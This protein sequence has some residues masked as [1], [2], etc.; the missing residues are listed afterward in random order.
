MSNLKAKVSLLV[1][2]LLV[3]GAFSV[4]FADE[5]NYIMNLS[6][7]YDGKVMEASTQA[8]GHTMKSY[9]ELK[10]SDKNRTVTITTDAKYV[11]DSLTI[12]WSRSGGP[13]F[14]VLSTGKKSATFEIPADLTEGNTTQFV[15]EAVSNYAGQ[16]YV[17]NSNAWKLDVTCPKDEE[18]VVTANMEHN[19]VGYA[20]G[21][22]IRA[23]A[24]DTI[25]ITGTSN[26]GVKLVAYK[27]DNGNVIEVNGASTTIA[28][29]ELGQGK[30][31][32]IV[33]QAADG[34]WSNTKTFTF[35]PEAKKDETTIEAYLRVNGV[36]VE[37]GTTVKVNANTKLEVEGVSNKTVKVVS[38]KWANG[39]VIEIS[40]TKAV[41]PMATN[42]Q[43]IKL[44]ITAQAS[45][46]KWANSKTF[47]I[48]MDSSK[49]GPEDDP[50]PVDDDDDELII[51]PWMKENK[52]LNKLAVSLRSEPYDDEEDRANKNIYALGEKVVYYVDYKN[53][54]KNI[55]QPVKLTLN[56]P[57]S[58]TV[59]SSDNGTVDKKAGT[60]TWLFANG[61][62]K[63]Q[64]GTKTVVVKFTSL[65][66]SKS[67]TYKRI[68]P[69]AVIYQDGKKKDTSA[70]INLIVKDFDEEIKDEHDP[71]MY[72]DRNADT[73]RPDDTITRAEGALVLTRIFGISTAYDNSKY[74]FPDLDETY[75]EARRA[76][77]AAKAYG[78]IEGFPDGNYYPN[79]TMT[80][81]EFMTIIARQIEE[82]EE[83]GFEVK[84]V[85]DLIKVYKDKNKVYYLS[86]TETYDEH[87][88]VAY[89][90][91][92]CRLNMTPVTSKNTTIRFDNPISR[93]EVAQL[94]NFYLLRAP[95]AV[96][97][98]T[99]TKF[100]DVSRNHKL[101]AD[102]VEATRP[103]HN[104]SLTEEG[105]EKKE[106]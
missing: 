57:L 70:V 34:K 33:A 19:G 30:K 25:K 99:T 100:S 36:V 54:G 62:E 3:I 13:L 96:T 103:T 50:T 55:T 44:G 71:Y 82:E 76:I 64:A 46:G 87:W 31:L 92:L 27:W 81:G 85:D 15:F 104:W 69:K 77:R 78:L 68:T 95:A 8:D 91:L 10:N 39:S 90:T 83:E 93:A 6:V 22:T 1:V 24:G 52:D 47:T 65:G 14:Q 89:A 38:Y 9:L 40:G 63:E 86:D 43:S 102:I 26:I 66:N 28:V 2:M 60:I 16:N 56:I 21:D 106:D 48:V 98:S 12:Y 59:V 7:S 32:S 42:F 35:L 105:T 61:L 97:R 74:D 58:Y 20:H 72:G 88:S 101:F 84:D 5:V 53:G 11:D 29:P 94:V 41:I 49:P 80:V 73:F 17:G 79:K 37:N 75:V 23:K 67:L 51:E 4:A 18:V 45:D